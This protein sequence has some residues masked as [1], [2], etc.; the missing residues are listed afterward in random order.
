MPPGIPLKYSQK[1]QPFILKLSNKI[2]KE[3]TNQNSV[4]TLPQ[5]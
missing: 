4:F 1:K 5:I 2:K 3:I